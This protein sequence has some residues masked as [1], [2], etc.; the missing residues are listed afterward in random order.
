MSPTEVPNPCA[1]G[2]TPPLDS[3][4]FLDLYVFRRSDEGSGLRGASVGKT[5]G[6]SVGSG[7]DE[8]PGFTP[9]GGDGWRIFDGVGGTRRPE[10]E[11]G[12]GRPGD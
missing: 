8:F 2:W 3:H 6:G 11:R 1:D 7:V 9:S 5:R 4:L 12:P 10:T